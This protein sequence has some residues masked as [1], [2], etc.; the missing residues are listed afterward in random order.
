LFLLLTLASIIRSTLEMHSFSSFVMME[1]YREN[2]RMKWH[3]LATYPSSPF[4]ANIGFLP[5]AIRAVFSD[6]GTS[7][8]VRLHELP[9]TYQAFKDRQCMT[10]CTQEMLT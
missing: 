7:E 3:Y 10:K 5:F 9:Q 8:G 6:S 2:D 1:Q 4:P